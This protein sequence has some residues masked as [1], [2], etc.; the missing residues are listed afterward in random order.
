MGDT[1]YGDGIMHPIMKA[2]KENL[3]Q[4]SIIFLTFSIIFG[5]ILLCSVIIG[6]VGLMFVFGGIT[7]FCAACGLGVSEIADDIR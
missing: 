3:Q 4:E 6:N 5:I 7:M 1:C 2:E